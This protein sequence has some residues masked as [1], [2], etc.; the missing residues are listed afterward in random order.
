[1]ATPWIIGRS[2]SILLDRAKTQGAEVL[3]TGVMIATVAAEAGL[4]VGDATGA[5][6]AGV[7]NGAISP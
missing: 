5:G 6:A 2:R 1:M 7:V 3:V 4:V